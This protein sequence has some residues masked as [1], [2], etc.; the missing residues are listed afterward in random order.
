[1]HTRHQVARRIIVRHAQKLHALPN[2]RQYLFLH[3]GAKNIYEGYLIAQPDILNYGILHSDLRN[4][5]A[6]W[7]RKEIENL[8][9]IEEIFEIPT[10]P[11]TEMALACLD[12]QIGRILEKMTSMEIPP[13]KSGSW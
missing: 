1:M 7:D 9:G 6:E 2:T 13:F 8:K 5:I 12:S 3:L 11:K 10:T 4:F